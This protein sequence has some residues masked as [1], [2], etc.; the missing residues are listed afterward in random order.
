MTVMPDEEVLTR[1]AQ[2]FFEADSPTNE[3]DDDLV[4]V[5]CRCTPNVSLCGVYEEG[6]CVEL[7]AELE[8]DD[9]ERCVELMMFPCLICGC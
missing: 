3:D 4:H 8:E 5:F 6:P 2:E 1:I 9:C 7:D